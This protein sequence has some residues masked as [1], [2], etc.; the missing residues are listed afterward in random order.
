[1]SDLL[2]SDD[3]T[4]K[5]LLEELVASLGIV[6]KGSTLLCGNDVTLSAA[7]RVC[8]H[9]SHFF[10]AARC[11]GQLHLSMYAICNNDRQGVT[12]SYTYP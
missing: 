6:M 5:D 10:F 2:F 9:K 8:S 7:D 11:N 4:E 12:D 1:M 3:D